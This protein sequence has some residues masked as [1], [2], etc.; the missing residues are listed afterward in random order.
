L[1]SHLIKN[2]GKIKTRDYLLDEIWEYGDGVFSRTID[3]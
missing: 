2:P 3:T 1:L